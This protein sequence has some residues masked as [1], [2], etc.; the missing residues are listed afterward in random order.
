MEQKDDDQRKQEESKKAAEKKTGPRSMLDGEDDKVVYK[1]TMVGSAMM[2]PAF[3]RLGHMHAPAFGAPAPSLAVPSLRKAAV[4]PQVAPS[5]IPMVDATNYSSVTP[6]ELPAAPFRLELHSHFHVKDTS[7]TRVCMVIGQ[8]LLDLGTDFVFKSAKGKWKV[9]KVNGSSMVEFNVSL[10]KT[11]DGEH[12]VEFQRRSGDIVS[13]MN[14]YTDVAQACKKQ[15]MLTGTGALKPLKHKRPAPST[16]TPSILSPAELKDSVKSIHQM[17]TSTHAD[18]QVQGV[19]ASISL[20][21]T[22]TYRDCMATLVPILVGL[23]NSDVNHVQR[24]ASFALARLCD[25][26]ECR[27]AFMA[28]DGWELIVTLAAGGPDVAMD[29]QRESLHV[30]EIL[31]PLYSHEL[32]GT[33]GAPAVLQLL[34]DWQSIADPRLKKHACGVHR[35]LTEAGMIAQ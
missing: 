15:A 27:R 32:A 11:G 4:K 29:L 2:P 10:Y 3:G 25:D 9:S 21:S 5:S 33:T 7:V 6:R 18:V 17:M 34:Q 12:V 23:A 24:C 16:L 13:M 1:S 35:A 31:C 22:T 8:K 30:L 26:P 28:S 19:L 14:M 20:S